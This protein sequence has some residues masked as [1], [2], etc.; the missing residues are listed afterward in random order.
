MDRQKAPHRHE[1][2][3]GD[4]DRQGTQDPGPEHGPRIVQVSPGGWLRQP[5]KPGSTQAQETERAQT[6]AD[7]EGHAQPGPLPPLR[8]Q[9]GGRGQRGERGRKSA[10]PI[11]P[12]RLSRDGPSTQI[13]MVQAMMANMESVRSAT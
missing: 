13:G 9:Q 4:H 7:Q 8:T 5:R 6:H 1:G 11:A 12:R 2:S 10:A 3:E